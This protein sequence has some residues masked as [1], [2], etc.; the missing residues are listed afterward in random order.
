MSRIRLP[1][2]LKVLL[3]GRTEGTIRDEIAIRKGQI[4]H[5]RP[6][7]PV[8]KPALYGF[9]FVGESIRCHLRIIHHLLKYRNASANDNQE[10]KL[11]VHMHSS[12]STQDFNK[13]GKYLPN[14]FKQI[15]L[16]LVRT[17]V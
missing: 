14:L 10:I 4:C 17:L 5:W 7:V 9:R 15:F 2:L 3:N 12:Q 11:Y 1:L 8:V 16:G 6:Q 13:T